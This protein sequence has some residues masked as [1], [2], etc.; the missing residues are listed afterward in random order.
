MKNIY[1]CQWEIIFLLLMK[2]NDAFRSLNYR[3]YLEL[4][5][6]SNY[7]DGYV[8]NDDDDAENDFDVVAYEMNYVND[9]YYRFD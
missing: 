2:S 1:S 4:L 7:D 9:N 5:R 3:C 6:R 8:G